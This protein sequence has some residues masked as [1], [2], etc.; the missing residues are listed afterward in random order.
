MHLE[1]AGFVARIAQTPE[2]VARLRAY[3]PRKFLRRVKNGR[4]YY[5]YIDPD[6]CKCAFLG[7]EQAMQNYRDIVSVRNLQQPDNVAPGGVNPER[8]IIEEDNIDGGDI[9]DGDMLDFH[10]GL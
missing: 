3:P 8:L 5:L 7:S 9:P 4:P 2:Q 1:D 6:T 10:S